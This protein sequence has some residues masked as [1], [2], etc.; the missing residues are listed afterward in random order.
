MPQ[1]TATIPVEE[2]EDSSDDEETN[3][4]LQEAL[5][6]WYFGKAQTTVANYKHRVNDFRKW[7]RNNYHGREIDVGLKRKH[8]RLYFALKAKTCTQLRTTVV[9]IKSLTKHLKKRR[10]T[11]TDVGAGFSSGKQ[12]PPKYSRN[13]SAKD[14]NLFFSVANER[15][16]PSTFY[17][18]QLLA[19]CGI[20]R[21]ALSR[22]AASD[23][24]Q[25]IHQQKKTYH[26]IV[27]KAKGNKSRQVAI[28]SKVGEGLWKWAQSLST[29]HLF[30]SKKNPG[31]PLNAA[32]LAQRIARIAKKVGLPHTS[33]HHFRHWFCSNSLQ[34]G[35]DLA[36]V[37]AQMGHASVSVTSRYCHPSKSNCSA[38]IDLTTESGENQTFEHKKSKSKKVE[39][40]PKK[41]AVKQ[42][43]SVSL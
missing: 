35:A 12:G 21:T 14:V 10:I 27:R 4:T 33:M 25:S 18:C 29:I 37:A 17:L 42:G 9:V 22:I 43:N 30:P 11:S 23:I 39:N 26:V 5:D 41:V 13:M 20:R 7:Y 34:N 31:H 1:T 28:H 36:T 32:S 15:N 38:M 19:Y 24:I 3:Y 40:I 6:D 8:L 16:D 2:Q